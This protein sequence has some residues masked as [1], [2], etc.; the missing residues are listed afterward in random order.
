MLK[1]TRYFARVGTIC[2]LKN[3]KD[4]HGGVLFFNECFSRFLNCAN[5]TKLFKASHINYQIIKEINQCPG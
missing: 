5:S 4:T 1:C 3:V 2:N